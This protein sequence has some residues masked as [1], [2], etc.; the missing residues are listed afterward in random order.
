[1]TKQHTCLFGLLVLSLRAT[2][3]DNPHPQAPAFHLAGGVHGTSAAS[4]STRSPHGKPSPEAQALLSGLPL[5]FEKDSA[6]PRFQTRA[7][8]SS[9][10][11]EPG[12]IRVS[13]GPLDRGVG[14]RFQGA[15]PGIEPH[16]ESPTGAYTNYFLGNR[17]T[18]WRTRREHYQAVRYDR[19]WPGI[20]ARFYGRGP[21]LEYNFHVSPHADASR[22]RLETRG[23]QSLRVDSDG[24]LWI[25]SSDGPI[26]HRKPVLYQEIAGQ[27]VEVAGGYQIYGKNRIGF[28]VGSYDQNNPLIIDP[29]LEFG[30]YLGGQGFDVALGIALDSANNVYITGY[31]QQADAFAAGQQANLFPNQTPR[32]SDA[33]LAKLD[34]ATKKLVYID[35]Y[36]GTGFEEAY[37]VAVDSGG[38]ATIVGITTSTDLPVP[39]GYLKTHYLIGPQLVG[40]YGFAARFSADGTQLAYGTYTAPGIAY[41][42]AVN[43]AGFAYVVGGTYCL[44]AFPGALYHEFA[45]APGAL[46]STCSDP[47][48]QQPPT[49]MGYLVRIG[50][51]GLLQYSTFYAPTY[52]LSDVALDTQENVYVA[53]TT[54][55]A[56]ELPQQDGSFRSDLDCHI[57]KIVQP[58]TTLAWGR[59][60]GSDQD[61]ECFRIAVDP[62]GNPY[63]TGYTTS[64]SFPTT[65]GAVQPRI[66]STTQIPN[67]DNFR[68]GST[69][70]L[71]DAI[72]IKLNTNNGQPIYSTFLGGNGDDVGYGIAVDRS[73]DAYIFG[74]TN[75]Q[76]FAI[77][78]GITPG[79]YQ[80]TYGGGTNDAFLVTLS[81]DGTRLLSSSYFGG[82]GRDEGYQVALDNAGN[83]WLAGGTD[84]V[85]LGATSDALS[86]VPH[87]TDGFVVK[88][89]LQACQ[90][91]FSKRPTG[92]VS[93]GAT[94]ISIGVSTDT[95]SCPWTISTL[96]PWL[97][98][99]P[100][101][102]TGSNSNV[103]LKAS[104]N[105]DS[106]PR[107]GIFELNGRHEFVYQAGQSACRYVIIPSELG[108][109][110]NSEVRQLTVQTSDQTCSWSASSDQS[111]LA[112][113]APG[114]GTGTGQIT[115]RADAN[116][117]SNARRATLTVGNDTVPVGQSAGCTITLGSSSGA[118]GPAG[119]LDAVAILASTAD[120]TW[121]AQSQTSWI[122]ILSGSSGV[123]PGRVGFAVQPNTDDAV[124]NGTISVNGQIL[125][126]L[127]DSQFTDYRDQATTLASTSSSSSNVRLPPGAKAMALHPSAVKPR[128][129]ISGCGSQ[130]PQMPTL[131]DH[132]TA[133]SVK[134]TK[135]FSGCGS[136]YASPSQ[137]WLHANPQNWGNKSSDA[138]PPALV[139]S[140]DANPGSGS[141][142]GTI[143]FDPDD[144]DTGRWYLVVNQVGTGVPVSLVLSP[145]SKQSLA[146]VSGSEDVTIQAS[147]GVSSCNWSIQP[148]PGWIHP[149]VQ[150]GACNSALH[151]AYDA[152]PSGTPRQATVTFN[153]G[154]TLPL[155]QAGAPQQPSC[156]S[157]S[158]AEPSM[159]VPTGGGTATFHVSASPGNCTWT[160]ATNH[161]EWVTFP[162][163]ASGTGNQSITASAL[164]NDTTG[165][166]TAKISIGDDQAV[167][168]LTED[169][170]GNTCTYTLSPT[171]AHFDAT[172]GNGSFQVQTAAGCSWQTAPP[173][174]SWLHVTSGSGTGSGTVS[175]TADANP[176]SPAR[177]ALIGVQDQTFTVNQDA[178]VGGCSYTLS[179]T[180]ANFGSTGGSGSFQVQTTGGC[181]W[182]AVITASVS[183][184]HLSGSA[185]GN[186]NGTVNF[187]VDANQGSPARAAS[188]A[189]QGQN[190]TVNQTGSAAS[191]TITA[192][193]NP[194]TTCNSQGLGKTTVT[195]NTNV[196]GTIQ[197]RIGAPD[198][199]LWNSGP[200]GSQ[201]TGEWFSTP[202]TIYLVG[203]GVILAQVTVTTTCGPPPPACT[204]ALS[205][206]SANFSSTA[207]GGSFQIQTGASCAWQA[208]SSASFLHI[209]GAAS[210][211]G[212]GTVQYNVDA[213]SGSASRVGAISVQQQN[214]TVTQA[215]TTPVHSG[216]LTASPGSLPAC[217]PPVAANV[218]LSWSTTN[219]SSV[220]IRKSTFNGTRVTSGGANGTVTV[221]ALPSDV[222]L[223]VDTSNGAASGAAAVLSQVAIQPA[224]CTNQVGT[225]PPTSDLA[226]SIRDWAIEFLGGQSGGQAA[227]LSAA[228]YPDL[229]LHGNSSIYLASSNVTQIRITRNIPG[230][231]CVNSRITTVTF[232]L[233]TDI[234]P[235]DWKSG[236]PYIRLVSANGSLTLTPN[237]EVARNSSIDWVTLAIPLSG[238]STWVPTQ[239]GQ[240]DARSVTQIQVSFDVIA[241]GWQVVFDGM[242]LK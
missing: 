85:N 186:G 32:T 154:D 236:S 45:P 219:V 50:T 110:G 14:L 99:S 4:Q 137:S 37:S 198:G 143:Q 209:T 126:L 194:I 44:S 242:F 66:G 221:S 207:G 22:I 156:D 54:Y 58:L 227:D 20:D 101:S 76:D 106:L 196:T 179:P 29:I 91:T 41:G 233:L 184:L 73:G 220:D 216:V 43:S 82:S 74:Y 34:G 201:E 86:Q 125:Q 168:Y 214:F 140:A 65:F 153:T 33:F 175:F 237:S 77:H 120:C 182:Q 138:N 7:E 1:M 159:D 15:R 26:R 204:Y 124:R 211:T 161:P 158:F 52:G 30:T 152:N 94:T 75:S 157:V 205:P 87:A 190:F 56:N 188:I 95:A 230:A 200:S 107:V 144:T 46:Q 164:G 165:T 8:G 150:Q 232:S 72:A 115:V 132:G 121:T 160:V 38:A 69:R 57:G 166:K 212:T 225:A 169:A 31:T 128:S 68:Y 239:T 151:L 84:S 185:S 88:L 130:Q 90:A 195:W 162:N 192:N 238:N 203:N 226:E 60:I 70:P 133:V 62:A 49:P 103:Q 224:T 223:L 135:S 13:L 134:V 187:T 97:S 145:N 122:S 3:A 148:L 172:G 118:I 10:V 171:S 102:G 131:D 42:V 2:A 163:G 96:S 155:L 177:S 202:S 206:S 104:A 47:P 197:V 147:D 213:N 64:P 71:Y 117:S 81:P 114:G 100:A 21:E 119:G 48:G 208:A 12:E 51:N 19:I 170:P 136:P 181:Q 27:R 210:G 59:S 127:Q 35:F 98:V 234:P 217:N 142:S 83:V 25:G 93:A 174:A 193:P 229:V 240:F 78:P 218:T 199:A 112:V 108:V 141:R 16:G 24:D 228:Q 39:N 176:S 109:S 17:S 9:V 113:V 235:G 215:G 146:P 6:A 5:Y 92:T 36:G 61:E 139:I 191:S 79:A 231:V 222:Y 23:A 178:P 80:T 167:T 53:G 63:A 67:P 105:S 183:W 28:W 189:V 18:Q 241:A 149:D 55:G 129:G 111:W 116:S 180:S 123:G 89:N 11:M 173:S 40:S